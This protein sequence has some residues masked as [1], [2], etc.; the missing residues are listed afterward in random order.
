MSEQED[1]SVGSA[2]V[3]GEIARAERQAIAARSV[4]KQQR[5]PAKTWTVTVHQCGSP[6]QR[7]EARKKVIAILASMR[8]GTGS[9]FLT[10]ATAR[11]PEPHPA[12]G[13]G[14]T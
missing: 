7:A 10:G 3:W 13:D 12:T 2:D 14:Q 5:K 8:E 6:E 11:K 4:A 1:R 9:G